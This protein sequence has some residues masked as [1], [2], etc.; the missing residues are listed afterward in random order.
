MKYI[1]T[2]DFKQ[3]LNNPLELPDG[4]RDVKK[5]TIVEIDGDLPFEKLPKEEYLKY[6]NFF[7]FPPYLVPLDSD[8]GRQI[9]ADVEGAKEL[10]AEKMKAA[11][12]AISARTP[13]W[14][15][16][17]VGIVLLGAIAIVVAAFAL[18]LLSHF[19]PRWFHSQMP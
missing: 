3:G 7:I 18:G 4:S 14:Y 19:F 10:E 12:D 2:R 11:H 15:Q 17:P 6:S 5:G 16:K 1:A 9:Q 8:Q 13:K